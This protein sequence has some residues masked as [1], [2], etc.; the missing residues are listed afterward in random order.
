MLKSVVSVNNVRHERKKMKVVHAGH[1]FVRRA[2]Q[3]MVKSRFSKYSP[4]HTMEVTQPTYASGLTN[5]YKISNKVSYMY[6][7]S[8]DIVLVED[9][10]A[11]TQDI[12][13]YDPD[14]VL[15]D[16]ATNNIANM[17]GQD[18]SWK[19]NIR[20]L[21]RMCVD[22]ALKFP[23]GVTVC[24]MEV[25]PRLVCR[26]EH[27]TPSRFEEYSSYFNNLLRIRQG[28]ALNPPMLTVDSDV[29]TPSN[30]RYQKMQGWRNVMVGSRYWQR[31]LDG[32]LS[33]DGI[34]PTFATYRD[35]YAR[36]VSRAILSSRNAPARL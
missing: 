13:R 19:Y 26:G 4:R 33:E 15:I 2:T 35:K 8:Q 30:F 14:F 36:S 24:F 20:L 3:A 5:A 18:P 6:T 22:I 11:R 16:I 34:H 9:I 29:K 28:E 1:S 31:E 32:M 17:S 23:T 25:V 27:M 7:C 10:L 12:L 21:V